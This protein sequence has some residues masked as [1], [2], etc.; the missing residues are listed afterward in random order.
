MKIV[1]LI[2]S[3]EGGGTENFLYQIISR[4]PKNMAHRVFFLKKDGVFGD[5]LRALGI[6]VAPAAG[7]LIR[8]LRAEQPDVLHTCLYRAHQLG[9][10]TGRL[11]GV[12]RIV[13]SQRAIDAWQNPLHRYLDSFT[14]QFCNAVIV[15]SAAAEALVR[16]RAG[17]HSSLAIARIPNGVDLNRFQP[18][19]RAAARR[20]LGL[21]EQ[22]VIAGSLMRLHAEKGADYIVRF[23]E[24]ALTQNPNLHLAIGGTG[25]LK[26]VLRRETA[27]RPWHTRLH[28]LG[29]VEN[30]PAFYAALD[31]FWLLSREESFPQSLLE[32]SC[33]GVPWV[34]PDVGGVRDLIAAGARGAMVP[35]GQPE[36]A[37]EAIAHIDRAPWTAEALERFRQTFSVDEMVRR[38][39]DTLSL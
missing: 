10:V 12:P 36:K 23:A 38:V 20:A 39:Y 34:A 14:L 24:A 27:R 37:A 15:N 25:P 13:S 6:S 29:W 26:D 33:M 4:S 16:E 11:A 1:H 32:A 2:T 5:R 28:W 3:L 30:A 31:A 21:P 35:T 19:E 8:L 9:R 22:A 7:G 17:I 18:M